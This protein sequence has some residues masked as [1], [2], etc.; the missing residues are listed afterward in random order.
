MSARSRNDLRLRAGSRSG[1]GTTFTQ[2]FAGDSRIVQRQ[3]C[4]C[5]HG[6]NVSSVHRIGMPPV[7]RNLQKSNTQIGPA[8]WYKAT[9]RV[10]WTRNQG[11]LS[12]EPAP[13]EPL[14]GF[15]VPTICKSSPGSAIAA[16]PTP[17]GALEYIK[18][19]L[20]ANPLRAQLCTIRKIGIFRVY[21]TKI[22]L[23]RPQD[24]LI[25][26]SGT[27][28]SMELERSLNCRPRSGHTF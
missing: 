20:Y 7:R 8:V 5:S 24:R 9:L 17:S 23:T 25:A 19:P 10:G 3:T 11:D 14:S 12:R 15:R 18:E 28:K 1:N 2:G 22:L 16:R 21:S 26:I 6:I 13:Q 27:G 4:F